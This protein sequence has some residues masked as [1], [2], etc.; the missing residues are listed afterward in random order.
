MIIFVFW[1]F[2]TI[3]CVLNYF[4]SCLYIFHPPQYYTQLFHIHCCAIGA[5]EVM[6]YY[7]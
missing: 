4:F 1:S 2:N 3:Q 6:P 7:L 5:S